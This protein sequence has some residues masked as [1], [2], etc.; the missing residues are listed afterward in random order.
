MAF[1]DCLRKVVLDR[2]QR[3][4]DPGG[5]VKLVEP[6]VMWVRVSGLSQDSVVIRPHKIALSGVKEGPWKQSCDY[7]IVSPDGDTVRVLFVELKRTL[8][9]KLKKGLEQLRWSLPR[10]EYLR[11]LCRIHCGG[12]PDRIVVRYALVA[13]KGSPRLDKQPIRSRGSPETKQHEGIEVGLHIVAKHERFS[14]LWGN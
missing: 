9:N 10:L 7:V 12:E 5:T 3:F 14:R 8:P 4:P 2:W 6:N 1:T 13:E 11:S